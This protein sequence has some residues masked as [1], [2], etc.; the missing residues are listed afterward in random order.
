MLVRL[1]VTSGEESGL[2]T[3]FK[4]HG[5]ESAN[6]QVVITD[7]VFAT[8]KVS[9]SGWKVLGFPQTAIFNGTNYLHWLGSSGAYGARIPDG[10]TFLEGQA[11]KD[12]WHEMRNEWL[13]AHGYAPR[14]ADDWNPM[15]APVAT[16]SRRMS[17]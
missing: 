5:Y 8:D 3:W 1:A 4:M 2:G 13:A 17:K 14:G 9:R 10:V 6:H 16:P 12:K 15:E 11:A 7:S